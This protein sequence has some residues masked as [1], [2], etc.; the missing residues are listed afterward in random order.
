MSTLTRGGTF[1]LLI[2]LAAGGL[3]AVPAHAE[4]KEAPLNLALA[5]PPPTPRPVVLAAT[6]RAAADD[7]AP[8]ATPA[9]KAP[10]WPWVLIAVAAAG[11]GALVF[12]SS[13]K[14][15]SCPAGR[16]CK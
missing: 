13:G 12:T 4:R 1:A 5:A 10:W 3:R 8:A 14:D 16:T 7:D 15:P 2:T 6:P 9:P 11:I